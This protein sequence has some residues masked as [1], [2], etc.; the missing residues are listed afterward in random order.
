MSATA[1]KKYKLKKLPPKVKSWI[2]RGGEMRMSHEE[3]LRFLGLLRDG[4]QPAPTEDGQ[5]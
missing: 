4:K 2:Y 3:C 1:D 5:R